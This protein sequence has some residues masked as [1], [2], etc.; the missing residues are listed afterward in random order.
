MAAVAAAIAV[1]DALGG[2]E[3]RICRLTFVSQRPLMPQWAG[4]G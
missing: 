4:G 2:A 3:D 1:L